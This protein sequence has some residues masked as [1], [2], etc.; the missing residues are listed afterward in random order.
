[1][2]YDLKLPKVFRKISFLARYDMMSDNCDGL[3]SE[4]NTYE[5]D[6]VMRHRVTSGITLSIAAPFI[7]DIRINYEKYFYQNWAHAVR[8][9][10]DK[11]VVE[12][13]ARF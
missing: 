8:S 10:Q 3:L 13:V 11:F 7:A 5:I 12:V 9:E 6:D 2:N 1:M 4:N